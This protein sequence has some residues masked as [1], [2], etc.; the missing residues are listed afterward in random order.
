V[1]KRIGEETARMAKLLEEAMA[2]GV[3]RP[4]DPVATARFMWAAW[5]GVIASHLGPANM[6]IDEP[7]FEQML[8]RAR[9]T[10]I[11][12]IVEPKALRGSAK[13]KRPDSDR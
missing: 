7:E 6:D 4:M 5:D 13:R 12:G 11:V 2:A 9:E 3:V 1:A 8:N 10:I